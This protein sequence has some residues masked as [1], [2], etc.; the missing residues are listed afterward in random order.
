MLC[1]TAIAV[2][3][4]NIVHDDN[5]EVRTV[6]SFSSIEASGTVAVYLSQGN[7]QGVA[8]SADE[9]KHNSK[10]NTEV[11]NGVLVISVDG[12]MWNGFNWKNK[13]LKVYV[14]VKDL[15]RIE[16]SGAAYLSTAGTLSMS[17][18]AMEVSGASE[19][20][21]TLNIRHLKLQMSGA[22]VA[23]LSGTTTDVSIEASGASKVLGYQLSVDNCSA[24]ATGASDIRLTVNKELNAEASGGSTIFYKGPAKAKSE[25]TGGSEI[26]NRSDS[27][28]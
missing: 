23:R 4:Q 14:T 12:G 21:G 13:Q 27:D 9:K 19:M 10:I 28:D 3:A 7:E 18:L 25:A 20:K 24:E 8:V 22:S 11:K 15:T 17:D 6:S 1:V 26:K 16:L 2:R 5:A